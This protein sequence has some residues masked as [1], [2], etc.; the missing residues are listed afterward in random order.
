[1]LYNIKNNYLCT[2]FFMVLDLRLNEDCGCR[3][4]A[5]SFLNTF[6]FTDS[7]SGIF[8]EIIAILLQ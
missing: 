7:L 3:E 4:T 8:L 2:V 6:Q 1:M 5:F